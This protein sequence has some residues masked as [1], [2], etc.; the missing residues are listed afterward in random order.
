MYVAIQVLR[1]N[2]TEE[3][4]KDA[5]RNIQGLDLNASTRRMIHLYINRYA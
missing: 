5:L 4:M 1:G 2:K 3:E